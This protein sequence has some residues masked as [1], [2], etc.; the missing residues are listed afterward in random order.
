MSVPWNYKNEPATSPRCDRAMCGVL[1][2]AIDEGE[3]SRNE[4]GR[5]TPRQDGIEGYFGHTS[6][7]AT[8]RIGELKI[9]ISKKKQE[10]INQTRTKLRMTSGP[11]KLLIL[12]A[13]L[14]QF[15]LLGYGFLSGWLCYL[16]SRQPPKLVNIKLRWALLSTVLEMGDEISTEL[17]KKYGIKPTQLPHQLGNSITLL[18]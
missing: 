11:K 1:N 14:H 16:G 18:T 13:P 6:S 10:T 2:I 7:R 5:R 8:K 15:F 17:S 4:G 12:G 3:V 9:E